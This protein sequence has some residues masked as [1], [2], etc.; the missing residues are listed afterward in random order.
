MNA[1]LWNLLFIKIIMKMYSILVSVKWWTLLNTDI[2][3]KCFLSSK[4]AYY[5]DFWRSCDTEDWSNDAEN[6]DSITGIY[7]ILKYIT[8]DNSYCKS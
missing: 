1:V 5:Y 7:Y 4:S 3:Q 2:N 6:T 8:I